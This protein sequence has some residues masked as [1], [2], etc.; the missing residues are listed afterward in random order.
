LASVVVTVPAE[1]AALNATAAA[2]GPAMPN[3]LVTVREFP[4]GENLLWVRVA[5][6]AGGI[7]RSAPPL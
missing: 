3:H 5:A 6:A 7:D 4:I 2:T 1:H